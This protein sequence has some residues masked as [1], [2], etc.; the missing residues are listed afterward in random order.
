[1]MY[2]LK[3]SDA[4][5]RAE[6]FEHWVHLRVEATPHVVGDF[7]CPMCSRAVTSRFVNNIWQWNH[8]AR[9]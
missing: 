6:P 8:V 5:L 2:A 9:S 7:I 4:A 1:M 3:A